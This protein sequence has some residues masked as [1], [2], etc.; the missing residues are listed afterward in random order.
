MNFIDDNLK[1]WAIVHKQTGGD[2][3][4]SVVHLALLR[5]HLTSKPEELQILKVSLSIVAY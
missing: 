5:T 3:A 1:F 4:A 2:T